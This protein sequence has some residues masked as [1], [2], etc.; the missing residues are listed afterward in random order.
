VT[1][2]TASGLDPEQTLDRSSTRHVGNERSS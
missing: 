2:T 1:T